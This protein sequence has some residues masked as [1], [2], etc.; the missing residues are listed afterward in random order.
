MMQLTERGPEYESVDELLIS[1]FYALVQMLIERQ[2]FGRGCTEEQ[3]F[4]E[5]NLRADSLRR[6]HL[7]AI[8][9]E[10]QARETWEKAQAHVQRTQAVRKPPG[11]VHGNNNDLETPRPCGPAVN[12]SG[13]TPAPDESSPTIEILL[14]D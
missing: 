6:N 2:V 5:L 14:V 11:V 8:D 10:K 9:A 1:Q 12:P 3:V 4:E 7:A 13:E